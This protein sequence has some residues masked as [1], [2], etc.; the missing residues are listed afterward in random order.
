[1]KGE[2]ITGKLRNNFT[3]DHK[4][5]KNNQ[6]GDEASELRKLDEKHSLT[7]RA[8]DVTNQGSFVL[9][10]K[11]ISCVLTHFTSPFAFLLNLYIFHL[12]HICFNLAFLCNYHYTATWHQYD[13]AVFSEP[14]LWDSIC[15]RLPFLRNVDLDPTEGRRM[16]MMAMLP[17]WDSI[18]CSEGGISASSA[19]SRIND[20]VYC[21]SKPEVEN[22]GH[23]FDRILP[24]FNIREVSLKRLFYAVL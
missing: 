10:K 18:S 6:E 1:M 23:V 14:G 3:Y 4:Q 22:G 16:A 20:V 12:T 7:N 5:T 21:M 2:I 15:S 8:T 11:I 24:S 17:D 9:S 19:L 13:D